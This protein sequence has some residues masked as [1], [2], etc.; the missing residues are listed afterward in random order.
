MFAVRVAC[1]YV[2]TPSI[3]YPKRDDP[4]ITSQP[5][6]WGFSKFYSGDPKHSVAL[7]PRYDAHFVPV[8][9]CGRS[10]CVTG[11]PLPLDTDYQAATEGVDASELRLTLRRCSACGFDVCT[12]QLRTS[13]WRCRPSRRCLWPSYGSRIKSVHHTRERCNSFHTRHI[14]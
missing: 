13:W 14:D 11:D 5:A 6:L 7:M 10:H 2:V 9:Y 1:A 4:S 12:L 3:D 8:K